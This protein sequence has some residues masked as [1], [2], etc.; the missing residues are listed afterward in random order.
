MTDENEEEEAGPNQETSSFQRRRSWTGH[1]IGIL[2]AIVGAYLAAQ[3]T[4]SHS[5]ND[6]GAI[7]GRA[8][9]GGFIGYAV[10][11]GIGKVIFLAVN[12][13]LRKI[14]E[15][16]EQNPASWN[17][18]RKSSLA[19]YGT[20]VLL[21]IVGAIWG[22][23]TAQPNGSNDFGYMLGG[24]LFGCLIGYTL[25]IG[26]GMGVYLALKG[27]PL[28]WLITLPASF[29]G[30]LITIIVC[31]GVGLLFKLLHIEDFPLKD[32]GSSFGII[33]FVLSPI[34]SANCGFWI[35]LKIT[36]RV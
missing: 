10:G 12:S 17:F 14:N 21:A 36:K 6:Y 23:Q 16:P 22:L 31:S 1:G 32:I 13:F 20:G 3:D 33:V 9:L 35:Y 27:F 26:I 18:I 28:A 5:F 2:L 4:R 34:I 11:Y 8:F 29:L 15:E 25:G 19:G 7:I 24:A 30:H